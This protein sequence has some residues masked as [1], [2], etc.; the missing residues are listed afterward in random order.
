MRKVGKWIVAVV[1]VCV[2]VIYC[3]HLFA[4][5]MAIENDLEKKS[6]RTLHPSVDE[7]NATDLAYI[8]NMRREMHIRE[9]KL[10]LVWFIVV[11][12]TNVHYSCSYE[13]GFSDFKVGDSVKLIHTTSEDEGDYGYIVGLH[14]KEQGKVTAIWN[15]NMDSDDSSP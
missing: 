9:G 6:A 5:Y 8:Y 13:S 2:P 12:A 10:I 4:N 14:E 15:F 3:G 7:G 11:P 1:I